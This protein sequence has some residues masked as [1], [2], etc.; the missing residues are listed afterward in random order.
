MSKDYL[1]ILAKVTNEEEHQT[2][3]GLGLYTYMMRMENLTYDLSHMLKNLN[4]SCERNSFN[5]EVRTYGPRITSQ[6]SFDSISIKQIIEKKT[7]I[8]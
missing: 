4:K 3:N 6:P 7:Q 8:E 5:W 1:D 2:S